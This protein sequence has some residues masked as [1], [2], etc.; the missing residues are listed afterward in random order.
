MIERADIPAF[1]SC[2]L[3]FCFARGR[4]VLF[5]VTEIE[6]VCKNK[7]RKAAPTL[8]H[9]FHEELLLGLEGNCWHWEAPKLRPP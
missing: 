9:S 3:P 6:N 4:K 5:K 8:V 2:H 1:G 7:P